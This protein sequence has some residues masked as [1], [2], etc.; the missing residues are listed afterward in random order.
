ME[1]KVE[2][3]EA[4]R[5]YRDAMARA[6]TFFSG[7]EEAAQD[8]VSHAFTRALANKLML[9]AM[10]EPAMKAWLYATA[11]NAVVDLKRRENRF[12]NFLRDR[13]PETVDSG[14]DDTVEK[15]VLQ[16]G[17]MSLLEK[18]PDPLR[19]PVELK[20]YEGMNATEIGEAMNLPAATVRTRLRTAMLRLRENSN[21]LEE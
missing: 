11:R 6:M 8:G 12:R 20:Y 13:A 10:P 7:D 5:E 19:I 18:L 4:F 1:P 2:I 14:Q 21:F 3:E 9:E 17:L 15:T 16:A